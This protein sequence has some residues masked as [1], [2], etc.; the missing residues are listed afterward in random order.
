MVTNLLEV[1]IEPVVVQR[2]ATINIVWE[3][4]AKRMSSGSLEEHC[5]FKPSPSFG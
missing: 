3:M 5:E 2:A 1:L 4:H